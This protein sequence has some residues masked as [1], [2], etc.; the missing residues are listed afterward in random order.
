MA[1]QPPARPTGRREDVPAPDRQIEVPDPPSRGYEPS[2]IIQL[3]IELQRDVATL[4]AKTDDIAD[5]KSK[6]GELK[7]SLVWVKGFAAAATILIPLC[8]AIIWFFV[9]DQFNQIKTQIIQ[10]RPVQTGPA[11]TP[12]TP[13]TNPNG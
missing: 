1:R 2:H 7:E 13:K 4:K 8:A 10:A 3:L 12:P 11:A 9:G 5:L 6:V